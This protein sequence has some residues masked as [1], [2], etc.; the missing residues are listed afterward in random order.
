MKQPHEDHTILSWKAPEFHHYKKN[1]WWFPLQALVTLVL[2][3]FFVLTKQY[4][5]AII[6]VL[7]AITIYQLAHQE[8]EV[9]PVIF[10]PDGIKFRGQLILYNRLKSFWIIEAGSV[11]KLYLQKIE[12]LS[13]P[14]SIPVVRE[15]VEKI[16]DFLKNYL[17]ERTDAQEDLADRVNRLLKI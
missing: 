5:V 1:E 7:G 2:T 14:V 6:V 13:A 10:S 4:L 12:R 9:S 16:R 3:A 17:P 8:P 11:R 15:D